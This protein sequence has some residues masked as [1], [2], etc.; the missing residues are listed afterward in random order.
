MRKNM[1]ALVN[2]KLDNNFTEP[3]LTHPNN[4]Q[5]GQSSHT[6]HSENTLA[7]YT[8]SPGSNVIP[9]NTHQY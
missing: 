3:N 7:S 9:W 8:N 4:N 5:G 6:H 1:H 2:S